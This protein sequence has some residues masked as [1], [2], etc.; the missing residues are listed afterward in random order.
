MEN[1]DIFQWTQELEIDKGQIDSDHKQLLEIANTVACIH[2]L[3]NEGEDLR[4]A[5]RKLY[6]YVKSH[7][8]REEAFMLALDYPYR[9]EHKEK[10]AEIIAMMNETL[11]SSHHLA[12]MR[13]KFCDLMKHWVLTHIGQE[14]KKINQFLFHN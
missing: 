2:D 8:T 5:I 11:T 1:A 7:F 9:E 4:R 14:D 13:D 10:H 6:E 3:D 12:E